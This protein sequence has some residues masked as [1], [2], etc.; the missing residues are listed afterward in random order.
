MTL[1]TALLALAV[2][3]V[4]CGSGPAAT[5]DAGP[6]ARCG[7]GR[8]DA[9]EECDQ[10]ALDSDV[11]TDA[12][13]TSCVRA[14]CGD[15]VVDTG[16]ACDGKAPAGAHC[17]SG[18]RITICG[19]GKVEDGEQCDD[20]ARNSDTH[21]D[22]C[23]ATCLRP[24]CGDGV[25]DGSEA[26]DDGNHASGDGCSAF[27]QA[28]GVN[29]RRHAT[30][31]PAGQ[32]AAGLACSDPGD[33]Q[34]RWLQPCVAASDC[35]VP[36]EACVALAGGSSCLP[37]RCGDA[38]WAG[39][40]K[41]G[42]L[43]GACDAT[44]G[45]DPAKADG[46]CLPWPDPTRPGDGGELCWRSGAAAPGESCRRDSSA[47]CGTGFTCASGSD[48]SH[49]ACADDAD[50]A[51]EAQASYCSPTLG[52]CE[53]VGACVE[54]CDVASPQATGDAGCV[55]D[56]AVC[57]PVEV[58][59]SAARLG[60]CLIVAAAEGGGCL[61]A[62]ALSTGVRC[63]A[64]TDGSLRWLRSCTGSTGC[65]AWQRCEAGAAGA[66]CVTNA[67][68]AT[69]L[70]TNG[71][72]WGGC[73]AT[74]G[75]LAGGATPD[76]ACLA[77]PGRL[78]GACWRAGSLG[79]GQGCR[80]DAGAVADGL[81][82]PGLE[83]ATDVEGR[84]AACAADADCPRAQLPDGTRRAGYCDRLTRACELQGSCR[85]PCDAT[86]ASGG[87]AVLGAGAACVP[88]GTGGAGTLVLGYCLA[89]P[90][91]DDPLFADQWHL[92]ATA[93]NSG[94][95]G[96]D[97]DVV[98]VW[99]AGWRGEGVTIAIVDDGLEIGHE[100]LVA[101]VIPGRSHDYVGGGV[102][103]TGGDHG[104][105]V[106]G[107]AAARD[108]NGLGVRG[109]APR[110]ALVGFNVL[111]SD[112]SS[113]ELDAE[114]RLGELVSV[115]NNSWGPPDGSGQ[116]VASEA[117]W[118]Q[119]I[120]HGTSQGRQGLGSVY[121]W[122]AGNGAQSGENSNYDGYANYYGVMAVCAVGDDGRRASYSERGANLWV[123]TPSLGNDDLGITTT[124]RSGADGYNDGSAG[125]GDVRD[126]AYTNTFSGTSS[127]TPVASGAAALVLQAN[128]RLSWRDVKLVL[129][130]TA[131]RNDP[132]SRSWKVNAAG[133]PVSHDYGF[134]VVDVAAAV[135][136]ALAW[137]P[138]GP[139][140][141]Y[142]APE[143]AP[144]L[145]I[146]DN[147]PRGVHSQVR[148]AGS[149]IA[150]LE[151]VAVRFTSDHAYA[152]DLEVVL[153]DETTGTESILAQQHPC[154]GP[155]AP[156]DA[157]RFGSARHLGEAADGTWTLVVRDTSANDTGTF[158]SW[159]LVFYGH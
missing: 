34:P 128:P 74:T 119:A 137:K 59:G 107:V 85:V 71:A 82:A 38:A 2:A 108:H 40:G 112:L 75:T 125:N 6:V 21:P 89:Q 154:A 70:G 152:G 131:R 109:V 101:N 47:T 100:D 52:T 113:N 150:S 56:L 127:A 105:A 62:G 123:C 114:T 4:A 65:R 7:D 3:L 157:W 20:G 129:A 94:H 134:G 36:W 139:M 39:A 25:I 116:L 55:D 48:T 153:T 14:R 159:Q 133:H 84:H 156:Y 27:C 130:S 44:S 111:A 142:A 37:N 57:V 80:R 8:V 141:T 91:G 46:A 45:A 26:C 99:A 135:A 122:A 30:C 95:P 146:P 97:I 24:T 31:A 124:D 103:P 12:C 41:N 51:S 54:S 147:D 83:C 5:P 32:R 78:D 106:A 86:S 53:P 148:V 19:N 115:Y 155:C 92:A 145:A 138:L 72:L 69:A 102:D 81:C 61:H 117:L 76:G 90:E 18:C 88:S 29:A 50:C 98:P 16:E 10:G 49:V 64:D 60:T 104:T 66:S 17:T 11:A 22:A 33:G 110:A 15:H 144:G 23:R 136:A 13:R 63:V 77:M 58:S 120:D 73:D 35:P 151:F 118:R 140:L 1:R 42:A 158:L 67:C 28:E 93:Q 9:T 143:A 96:E 43:F 132:T 68:G 87:C 121:T 126:A 149:G 79:E